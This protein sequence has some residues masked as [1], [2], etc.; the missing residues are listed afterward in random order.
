MNR[1]YS[2]LVVPIHSS[3]DG[4]IDCLFSIVIFRTLN[5]NIRRAVNVNSSQFALNKFAMALN[6]S[7]KF[8]DGTAD[9]SYRA[10]NLS[11]S[12]IDKYR[13][14]VGQFYFWPEVKISF[15][16]LP[17]SNRDNHSWPGFS[18]AL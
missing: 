12:D 3:I 7:L 10:V 5:E 6:V 2:S 1:K 15:P 11:E 8:T 13:Q 18:F 17:S 14:H 16:P 9:K 4:L